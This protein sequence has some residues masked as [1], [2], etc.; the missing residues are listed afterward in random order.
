MLSTRYW[1]ID[2]GFRHV[3]LTAGEGRTALDIKN[4]QMAPQRL[5]P[6]DDPGP[7]LA[8]LKAGF[9][10]MQGRIDPPSSLERMT[11]ADLSRLA[12]EAE[13]W[14]LRDGGQLLACMILT[15]K[16]DHLY[17][18]K[19]T[20]AASHRGHGLA[21]RLIDHACTRAQALGLPAVQLQSRVELLENH[22]AFAAMGFQQIAATAHPG[23]DR[24][25]SLTFERRV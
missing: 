16:P 20:V 22:M 3:N 21:R 10:S 24:P 19:L 11:T 5:L 13:I 1:R 2:A 17:L 18:G 9:A 25:T 23:F 14:V 4:N 12:A 7:M 8:L 6:Q 15:R